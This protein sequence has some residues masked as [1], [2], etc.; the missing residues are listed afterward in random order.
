MINFRSTLSL[1]LLFHFF[2]APSILAQ[3]HPT[4]ASPFDAIRW[5]EQQVQV[6]VEGKWYIPIAIDGVQVEQILEKCR[7]QWPGQLQKRFAEDLMEAMA[8]LGH[9]PGGT[10]TLRLKASP[11]AKDVV[12]EGIPNTLGKRQRL[13]RDNATRNSTPLRLP[14]SWLSKKQVEEEIAAFAAALRD[15]FAYLHL[16]G[17]DLDA[18]IE[19]EVRNYYSR[20]LPDRMPPVD[21]VTI[22]QRVLMQFGDGHADIRSS[23][24]RLGDGEPFNPFLLGDIDGKVVAYQQKRNNLLDPKYPYVVS[25]DG[26]PIEDCIDDMTPFIASGSPQLVR[27]RAIRLLRAISW[28]RRVEDGGFHDHERVMYRPFDLELSSRDGKKTR[29]VKIQPTDHKPPYRQWPHSESR[30][31]EENIGYLR[32]ARMD[33]DATEEVYRWMPRFSDT[34]GLIVD[35]RGNGGG[36]RES[37]LALAGFLL[38]DGESPWVGNFAVYRKSSKFDADHLA[39]RFMR[40]IDSDEWTPE[41]RLTIDLAFANFKPE[42]QVPD[43]FSQ[44]HALVLD[45]TGH[46][47]EFAYAK[48]VVIL[49]DAGCFSATDIFLGALELHQRVTLMGTSSS[50]G[51]ARSQG[52]DLPHSLIEV[53]CA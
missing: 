31:L 3:D 35:V 14:P 42:W 32:L 23:N 24:F 13:L 33:H 18:A 39:N 34:D 50:G 44:W 6:Q 21:L 2:G 22:L 46:P 16:K 28:W 25:L 15:Q 36:S 5:F 30:L 1:L 40:R 48:E 37:L 27:H 12:L 52:F 8:L 4:K 43:G 10:V 29:T 11:A 17:I 47:Q 9:E 7:Q 20:G 45:R 49:S 53:K 26:R 19:K 51:S 38:G 41:Q